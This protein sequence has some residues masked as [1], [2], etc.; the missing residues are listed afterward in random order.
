MATT[1]SLI[2]RIEQCD[3]DI[4]D[5]KAGVMTQAASAELF[6]LQVT[7]ASLKDQWEEAR[8][9][10]EQE[11]KA[12]QPK[13]RTQPDSAEN[14]A[15]T[16]TTTA[17]DVNPKSYAGMFGS[18]VDLNDTAGFDGV[19]EIIKSIASGVRD[20]R[21]AA[22]FGDSDSDGGFSLPTQ[23]VSMLMDVSLAD[24]I[25][26]PRARIIPLESGREYSAPFWDQSDR[27]AGQLFG[28]VQGLWEGELEE[29]TSSQ[30]KMEKFAG[31]VH[32]L[33]ILTQCSNELLR[34]APGFENSLLMLFA[35]SMGWFLDR[36]F[37][38]GSGTGKP[39]GILNSPSVV[40]IAKETGQGAGTVVYANL[41]KMYSALWSAGKRRGTWVVNS[42][43]IPALLNISIP[44]GTA[45]V[46]VPL[47]RESDGRFFIFG[48][49][50]VE[51]D[52]VPAQGT[53]GDVSLID[54][55][56]YAVCMRR[57]VSIDKTEH[58]GFKDNTT[59]FRTICR[60]DG[61]SPWRQAITPYK[62]SQTQSWAVVLGAR[63]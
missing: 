44:I 8:D 51:T 6:Q 62:G 29:M 30:P 13:R 14:I 12:K 22:M 39:E 63:A 38:N 56:Q 54:F 5:I 42:E 40:E 59:W 23:F 25:V 32:R 50:V 11:R 10:E 7:R 28:G 9:R 20:D 45:G 60:A 19:N 2:S 43:L 52:L 21:M 41:A 55:S 49:P 37:F 17:A 53:R 61:R 16:V 34:D 57:D 3:K 26:R 36:D 31:R 1:Q 4:A 24:E 35:K 27:S 15:H 47:M 33:N 58:L 18:K 46:F 48:L